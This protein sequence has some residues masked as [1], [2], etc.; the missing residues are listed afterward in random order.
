[1]Q[2]TAIKKTVVE[3]TWNLA[4]VQ[5]E[6]AREIGTQFA[7]IMSILPQYGVKAVEEFR[8]AMQAKKL[9]HLHT[10]GIKT[11]YELVKAT[12]EFETNVFGSKIEIWGDEKEAGMTYLSCGMWEAMNKV[13]TMTKEQQ[14]EMAKGWETC[15]TTMATRLGY[16]AK[17]EM[18][19]TAC[20]ITY[21]K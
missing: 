14:D 19:E 8:S 4:Q 13:T 3:A 21:T 7:T 1:M 18:T 11:P 6:A 2:T 15:V 12:A 20:T 17:L 10:L 16:T 5:Q 9:A